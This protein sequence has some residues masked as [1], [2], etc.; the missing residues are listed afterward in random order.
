MPLLKLWK[1]LFGHRQEHLPAAGSESS[2]SSPDAGS[3]RSHTRFEAP[4][5]ARQT[6]Q[7][8]PKPRSKPKSRT[9]KIFGIGLG[10]QH[11]AL[12]KQVRRVRPRTILEI[13]VGDGSRAVEMMAA[14]EGSEPVR[15]VAIDQFE[16][17]PS[18]GADAEPTIT[19]KSFHQLLRREGV[20]W[21]QI[22]PETSEAGLRRVATTIGAVDLVVI[23]IEREH[24]DTPLFNALLQRVCHPGTA[25]ISRN[26]E[27]W[28]RYEKELPRRRA[29]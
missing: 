17:S 13:S 3:D 21:A 1:S 25:I 12:C 4:A 2:P 27:N 29:A 9:R 7:S 15:Y 16:M 23:A 11:A 19:L 6:Q 26:D 5:V 22:F 28:V 10:G 14:L 24:W 8:A 20:R 18:G